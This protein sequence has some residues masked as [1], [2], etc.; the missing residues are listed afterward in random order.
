MAI[1]WVRNY[2]FVQAA[3]SSATVN[4]TLTMTTG[5]LAVIS[6]YWNNTAVS[7]LSVAG[8]G[9]TWHRAPNTVQQNGSL[10]TGYS[11]EIWYGNIVTGGSI[12]VTVALS[13][14]HANNYLSF[15]GAE[16][17]GV[18]T[19]DQSNSQQGN[20]AP[21]S[22]SV[23]TLV[24]DELLWGQMITSGGNGSVG[25]GWT[26][27]TSGSDQYYLS[28]YQIVSSTGSQQFTQTGGSQQ[29]DGGIATFSLGAP[30]SPPSTAFPSIQTFWM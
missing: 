14:S 30:P 29:Y 6:I 2:A 25:A 23:V 16:F 28:A 13:A 17:S 18:D 26:L 4:Q 3:A 15:Y 10:V 7:V 24:A 8:S 20:A 27:V 5:D 12:S 9:V 21:T 11:Q 1:A 22:P 19:I